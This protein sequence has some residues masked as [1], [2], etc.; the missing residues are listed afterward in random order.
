MLFVQQPKH[1][2]FAD[3]QDLARRDRRCAPHSERL[4]RQAPLAK[5]VSW[6]E[7]RHNRLSAG[8]RQHRY[9][10]AAVL[11]LHDMLT[12]VTLREDGVTS[13][14]LHDGFRDSRRIEK[15]L[16]VEWRRLGD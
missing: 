15:R 8:L 2:F 13:P 1:L 14:V 12:G 6:P 11:Y 10:N 16:G 9:L 3:E 4:T 7:H 5:E